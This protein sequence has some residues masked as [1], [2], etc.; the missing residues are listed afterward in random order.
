MKYTTFTEDK[1]DNKKTTKWNA[2]SKKPTDAAQLYADASLGI[3]WSK[4]GWS[5]F[6]VSEGL[7]MGMRKIELVGKTIFAIDYEFHDWNWLHVGKG[8]LQILLNE[9]KTIS[10]PGTETS[11]KVFT[12]VKQ[13]GKIFELGYWTLS[14][15]QFK[16]ICE[17][18]KVEVRVRAKQNIE[19]EEGNN[20]DFRFMM[21]SMYNESVDNTM[22]VEEEKEKEKD[23]K[24][25][26]ETETTPAQ[27][28]FAS[29][30]FI[31]IGLIIIFVLGWVI[32]G[33]I[34]SGF[35]LLGLLASIV[36]L[37]IDSVKGKSKAN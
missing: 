29:L 8:E 21:R 30:I 4:G 12:E 9:E 5:L 26:K 2:F 17:A 27:S 18:E 3:I 10:L 36:T 28:I 23:E 35:G 20:K 14:E 13:G 32:I 33:G 16:E 7:G 11:T 1:F 37:I 19:F 34:I 25:E 15:I 6:G 24:D 22:F 31:A